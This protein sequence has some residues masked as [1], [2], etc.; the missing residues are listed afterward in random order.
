MTRFC[1]VSHREWIAAPLAAVRAQ[2]ADLQHHIRSNVHPKLRLELLPRESRCTR[3][4]QEVRLLGVRQR[5]VFERR[6]H[7]DGSFVDTSIEGFNK[8]GT[9][10][11]GFAREVREGRDGTAV[12]ITVRLPLPPLVG[13]LLHGPLRAQVRREVRA[14]AAEDKYDLEVRGYPSHAPA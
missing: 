2:F 12:D 14:A 9:V 10:A 11:F 5:D 13:A 3:F 4:V 1:E 6:M 7:D 8:G